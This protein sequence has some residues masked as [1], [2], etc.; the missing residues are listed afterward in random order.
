MSTLVSSVSIIT[1]ENFTYCYG[2]IINI[3]I[4]VKKHRT[5]NQSLGEHMF[6]KFPI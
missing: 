1:S 6:D 3:G 2:K 5:Y 4:Y